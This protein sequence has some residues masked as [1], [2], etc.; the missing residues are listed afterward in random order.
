MAVSTSQYN[1]L[2]E[3]SSFLLL[4]MRGRHRLHR[5]RLDPRGRGFW[6]ADRYRGAAYYHRRDSQSKVSEEYD[7][8]LF[9][10]GFESVYIQLYQLR[11]HADFKPPQRCC[12]RKPWPHLCCKQSEFW[13]CQAVWK[14]AVLLGGTF[15]DF[16]QGIYYGLSCHFYKGYVGA[17]EAW[18]R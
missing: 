8:Q 13:H 1:Y 4:A 18:L 3:Y 10:S 9:V 7:D 12:S 17:F 6:A 16:L 11:L 2:P 14:L 5:R 15:F